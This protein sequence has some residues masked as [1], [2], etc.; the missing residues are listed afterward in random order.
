M[1][2]TTMKKG[3]IVKYSKPANPDEANFRFVLLDAPE[4]RPGGHPTCL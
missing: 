2:A 4:K 3:D 1:I